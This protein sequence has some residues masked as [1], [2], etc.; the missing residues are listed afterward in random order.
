M[1]ELT[2]FFVG[3][4]TVCV[5]WLALI[6]IFFTIILLMK[7]ALQSSAYLWVPLYIG[8]IALMGLVATHF[9]QSEGLGFGSVMIIMAEA[10]RMMMKAHS[11]LRTKLIYL[12]D[13]PYRNFEFRGVQVVNTARGK[14]VGGE[15][16][17]ESNGIH[18]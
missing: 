8:H 7:F 1:L 4:R 16:K 9:S 2:S 15:G 11:Y 17:G 14:E 3:I 12:T 6:S 5:A 10:I 18:K 13:N